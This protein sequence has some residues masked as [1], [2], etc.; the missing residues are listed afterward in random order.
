[1]HLN[2]FEVFDLPVYSVYPSS[3][4]MTLAVAALKLHIG[5]QVLSMQT[6]GLPSPDT[7]PPTS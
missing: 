2:V 4:Q 7:D 3:W 6:S 1:M 5:V